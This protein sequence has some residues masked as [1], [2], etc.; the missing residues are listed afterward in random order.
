M[1]TELYT[2]KEIKKMLVRA[3]KSRLAALGVF[4]AGMA[5]CAGL[6]FLVNTGNAHALFLTVLCLSCASGWGA[7]LIN[8]LVSAPARAQAA[9]MKN[10]LSGKPEVY[11]GI[12]RLD[13][14]VLQIP[15]SI[16]IQKVYLENGEEPVTLSLNAR[17]ASRLPLNGTRVAVL[18]AHKY[19][20]A[21]EVQD[22]KAQ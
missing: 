3:G 14:T 17:Y 20:I 21:Y 12:L 8:S 15:R 4:G 1:M 9:H 10:T 7:I 18:A 5:G 13:K 6:C 11:S 16:A 22:E 19:V 2:A